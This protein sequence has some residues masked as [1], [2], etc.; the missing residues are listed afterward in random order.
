MK[1]ITQ[2]FDEKFALMQKLSSDLNFQACLANTSDLILASILFDY[3]DGVFIGEVLEG[4]FEQTWRLFRQYILTESDQ[5]I[6]KAKYNEYLAL[7]AKT[8]KDDDK[9]ALYNALSNLRFEITKMQFKCIQTY[10]RKEKQEQ[11]E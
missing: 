7:T 3:T 6:L 1:D 4:T 8:Y 9:N 11:L 5:N 10:K 2:I